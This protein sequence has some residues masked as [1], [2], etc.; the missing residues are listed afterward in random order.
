MISTGRIAERL[1]SCLRAAGCELDS[2][3]GSF[4]HRRQAFR[5]Q[6]K[7]SWHLLSEIAHPFRKGAMHSFRNRPKPKIGA[8]KRCYPRYLGLS[9]S[10]KKTPTWAHFPK[11]AACFRE[12]GKVL[13]ADVRSGSTFCSPLGFRILSA[14]FG[15][16]VG[17][18]RLLLGSR[19]R[20]HVP[21]GCA[22]KSVG[23]ARLPFEC[24]RNCLYTGTRLSGAFGTLRAARPSGSALSGDSEIY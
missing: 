16:G 13:L 7:T 10:R 9:K 4:L 11:G 6:L 8:Q 19:D 21:F 3:R 1:G 12:L 5:K 2:P 23:A 15:R 18:F 14:S 22:G 24:F 17:S 20:G